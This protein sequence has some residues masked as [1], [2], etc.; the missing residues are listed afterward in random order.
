MSVRKHIFVD[1]NILIYAH[2]KDAG[3]KYSTAIEK[4]STLWNNPYPPA[5][6][7]QV[8][9]EFYVN[10]T[11]KKISHKKTLSIIDNYL[12]WEVIENDLNIFLDAVKIRDR[13]KL[14]FWDSSIIAAAKQARVSEIW[15]EDISTE[16]VYSGIKL[17]NPLVT[18]THE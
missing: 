5:I 8:L 18:K 11:R 15:S 14:S 16:Q 12:C 1:T 6:S 2:D 4:L 3:D 7:V 10:L 9:Q 13:Y 17:V